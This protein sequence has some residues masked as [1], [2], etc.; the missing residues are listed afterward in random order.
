MS[1]SASPPDRIAEIL[2]E[3]L[4]LSGKSVVTGG[5]TPELGD[6]RAEGGETDVQGLP[7]SESEN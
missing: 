3:I 4:A 2:R 1:A 5:Q 7:K 6:Q